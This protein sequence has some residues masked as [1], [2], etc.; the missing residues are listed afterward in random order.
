LISDHAAIVIQIENL[1]YVEQ[2]STPYHGQGSSTKKSVN[3][4]V[5]ANGIQHM[6]LTGAAQI[7]KTATQL[8]VRLKNKTS[9]FPSVSYCRYCIAFA[10]I[11]LFPMITR[12]VDER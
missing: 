7:K 8:G 12:K 3:R 4:N 5:T 10:M 11:R 2:G 6:E 1:R 9:W